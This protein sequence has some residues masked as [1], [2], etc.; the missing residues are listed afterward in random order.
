MLEE[1]TVAETPEELGPWVAQRPDVRERLERGG[2]GAEFSAHDLHPLLLVFLEKAGWRPPEA[3]TPPRPSRVP[4][5]AAG[6]LLLFL[7]LVYLLLGAG[8]EAGSV[9]TGG[10]P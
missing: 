4:W 3:A 2:Y 5:I 10:E 8:P 6:L 7:L 1:G 9:G